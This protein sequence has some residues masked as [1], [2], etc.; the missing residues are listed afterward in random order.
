MIAR[1]FFGLFHGQNGRCTAI[2]IALR[3]HLN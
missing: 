1:F 3:G 2:A